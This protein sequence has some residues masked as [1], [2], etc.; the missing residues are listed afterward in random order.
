MQNAPQEIRSLLSNADCLYT[1][2]QVEE[3]IA[4]L[5]G[6]ISEELRPLNPILLP[7]M[8]GGLTVAAGLLRHLDFPLQ[9]DYMH[10]TRYR[11]STSGGS[12]DWIYE[13]RIALA[14]RHVLL[15]DDL[16]DHGITLEAAV[17][18]CRE[19]GARS[20]K[21]AVLIVKDLQERLGLKSVDYCALEAPDLYLFGYGMDYKSYWRNAPGIYAVKS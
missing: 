16:L 17:N 14:E 21:T 3:A 19:K 5:A 7:I 12:L 2:P 18:Y 11:D 1:L 6:Q 8:N 4:T 13:P 20:V 9:L 10:V 15:I